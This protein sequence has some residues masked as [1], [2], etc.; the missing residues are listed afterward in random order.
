MVKE[1]TA[2]NKIITILPD[3]S[4]YIPGDNGGTMF[5]HKTVYIWI[6]IATMTF[7]GVF[8]NKNLLENVDA[9]ENEH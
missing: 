3:M 5:K 8:L 6:L 2:L 7:T 9:R 4:I 1:K